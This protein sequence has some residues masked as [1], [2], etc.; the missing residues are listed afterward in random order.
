MNCGVT[1]VNCIL[2]HRFKSSQIEKTQ[3]IW[4]NLLGRDAPRFRGNGPDRVF[5]GC[6]YCIRTTSMHSKNLMDIVRLSA[7][8]LLKLGRLFSGYYV[9]SQHFE[10][11]TNIEREGVGASHGSKCSL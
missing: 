6:V 10:S 2:Y 4:D 9:S 7:E 11:K 8:M 5:N 3:F 1:T